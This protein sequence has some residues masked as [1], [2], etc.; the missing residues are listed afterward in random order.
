MKIYCKVNVPSDV[1]AYFCKALNVALG[2]CGGIDLLDRGDN[3]ILQRGVALSKTVIC[4]FQ[5]FFY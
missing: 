5:H 4:D 1:L 2:V 3:G